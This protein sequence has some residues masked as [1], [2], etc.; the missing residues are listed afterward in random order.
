MFLCRSNTYIAKGNRFPAILGCPDVKHLQC[1]L[2]CRCGL[3]FA[4]EKVEGVWFFDPAFNWLQV[5]LD[6][7]FG[8]KTCLTRGLANADELRRIRLL[9]MLGT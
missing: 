9:L 3:S 7:E 8:S 4:F 1:D 5:T 2:C 6:D